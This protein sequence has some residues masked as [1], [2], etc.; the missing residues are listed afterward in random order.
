MDTFYGAIILQSSL[1]RAWKVLPQLNSAPILLSFPSLCRRPTLLSFPRRQSFSLIGSHPLCFEGSHSG[2]QYGS[3]STKAHWD[4]EVAGSWIIGRLIHFW[5]DMSAI[6][7]AARWQCDMATARCRKLF[8]QV[9]IYLYQFEASR[10]YWRTLWRGDHLFLPLRLR[11]GGPEENTFIYLEL[12]DSPTCFPLNQLQR[13]SNN[14][15][16]IAS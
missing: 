14:F 2:E 9:Q 6:Y 7:F 8:C 11:C 5:P 15:L 4:K 13:A 16:M 3:Y 12:A 10:C 1:F